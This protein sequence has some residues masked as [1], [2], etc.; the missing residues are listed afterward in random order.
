MSNKRTSSTLATK[1]ANALNDGRTSATTKALAASILS[2][3]GDNSSTSSK[4]ASKAS[5][6]LSNPQSSVTAKSLA[7]SALAQSK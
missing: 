1:A 7:G 5:D 3:T 6:V 2:Q 4:V